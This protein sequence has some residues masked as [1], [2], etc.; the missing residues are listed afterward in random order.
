M[1]RLFETNKRAQNEYKN[2]SPQMRRLCDAYA[3]GINYYLE[4]HPE[5]RP[6]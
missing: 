2:L 5:V 3:A 4:R 1:T 6:D